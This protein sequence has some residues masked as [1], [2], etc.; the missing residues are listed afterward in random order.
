MAFT[1]EYGARAAG[2]VRV[3]E[4][5]DSIA[6]YCVWA[7]EYDAC[8]TEYGACAE[9][10]ACA[11]DCRACTADFAEYNMHQCS[12]LQYLGNRRQGASGRGRSP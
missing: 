9:Y 10:N 4:Y 12:R 5:S 3:A 8:A 7:A 2:K 1:I 6:E 11:A